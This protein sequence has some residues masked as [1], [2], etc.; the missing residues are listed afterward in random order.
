[1]K[2]LL[3][4][5]V[6]IL[7]AY[8]PRTLAQA[9]FETVLGQVETNNKS[10]LSERQYWEAQK[11]TYR[12]GLNPENPKVE[13]EH[14]PGRPEGAGVQKDFSV[15]QSLDFPTAYGKKRGL[16]HEQGEQADLQF[17]AFRQ[18]VLLDT[19]LECVTF[20]FTTKVLAELRKR[21]AHADALLQATDQKVT[22][23]EGSIIDL[24][25]IKLLK[26]EI[27]T[28][29]GLTETALKVS[30]HK[31]DELN[32]GNPID[33]SGLSYPLIEPLPEFSLLDSLIEANDPVVKIVKQ[34]RDISKQ[35][36]ALTKSL[37]L[38]KLE[39][40]YHQ[41]SILGQYYQGFHVGLTVP[42]WEDKNRVKAG[43]AQ[44]NVSEFQVSEHRTKHYFENKQMYEQYLHWQKTLDEYQSILNSANNEVLVQRAFQAGQLS[45]IEYLMEI[46]FFYDAISRNLEAEKELQNTVSALYKLM[47]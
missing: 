46:R 6:A 27:N 34:E 9:G 5:I 29:V 31:L 14:L 38:P 3:I 32:G 33:L 42:L 43:K 24:N 21:L 23:G 7:L 40:G 44:Q 30:Q 47:L 10:I 4:I 18:K 11:L 17:N 16:A 12:T 2:K 25:K 22:A 37:A 8:S 13:Y 26:L 41:Q 35:Q 28:Q 15:M 39:G 36:I 20:I 45:L 19:K 1:M